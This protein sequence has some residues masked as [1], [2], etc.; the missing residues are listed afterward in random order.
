MAE[1]TTA[2]TASTATTGTAAALS[3]D[4]LKMLLNLLPIDQREAVLNDEN[5][6]K[7]LA[8]QEA[9]NRAVL[10]AARANGLGNDAVV[11]KLMQRG[12]D[13]VLVDVYL[14]QVIRGN[15]PTDFPS[16]EQVREYYDKNKDKFQT[17]ERMHLWQIYLPFDKDAKQ[18]EI[19]ALNKRANALVLDLR[20]GK[21][22][23]EKVAA[24]QSQHQA[25]RFNGGYLGLLRR[26]ELLP[27]VRAAVEGMSEGDISHPIKS[28]TGFHI[29]RRG[30][31]VPAQT[32]S[33]DDARADI[34]QLLIREA[35]QQTRSAVLQKIQSTYPVQVDD[36]NLKSW[37]EQLKQELSAASA[38]KP[39]AAN[40]AQN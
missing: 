7:Q 34:K 14:N 12:A 26:E 19:D 5:A 21:Q 22:T 38:A 30:A 15:L 23:F 31:T 11:Q 27:E 20:R 29:V 39:A 6:F 18:Q 10:T 36:K 28:D 1:A 13:R 3:A 33:F 32:L 4:D 35:I 9:Q 24:E 17:P 25:S 8:Q 37:R 16:D 40:N 2:T